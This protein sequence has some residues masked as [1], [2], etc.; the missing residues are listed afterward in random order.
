MFTLCFKICFGDYIL[1]SY[2]DCKSRK[3]V[4]INYSKLYAQRY[5]FVNYT[6]LHFIIYT[7]HSKGKYNNCKMD[8]ATSHRLVPGE[9]LVTDFLSTGLVLN[10][11]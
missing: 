6:G 9:T 5:I 3:S 7:T 8:F 10:G 2:S 11:F 4:C 1:K